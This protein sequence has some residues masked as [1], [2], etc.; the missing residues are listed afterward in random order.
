MLLNRQRLSLSFQ[1]KKKLVSEKLGEKKVE[2]EVVIRHHQ[3]E[4]VTRLLRQMREEGVFPV[5]GQKVVAVAQV[6]EVA[7]VGAVW[8]TLE[9]LVAA[10]ESSYFNLLSLNCGSNAE[11]AKSFTLIESMERVD[12]RDSGNTC[13][14]IKF[15]CRMYRLQSVSCN[16]SC[17]CRLYYLPSGVRELK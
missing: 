1:L 9:A 8:V 14:S 7:L 3:K 10:L 4:G 17:R 16:Q 11:R 12:Y 6:A 5:D 15:L 2:T 13:L